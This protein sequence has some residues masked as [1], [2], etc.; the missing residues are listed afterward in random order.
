VDGG[1]L[2]SNCIP[3]FMFTYRIH[4]PGNSGYSF[5]SKSSFIRIAF[6]RGSEWTGA[7]VMEFRDL[8]TSSPV[9]VKS[10]SEEARFSFVQGRYVE[11]FDLQ[12]SLTC[13]QFS[14]ACGLLELY[15]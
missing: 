6:C 13:F 5:T 2:E 3:K 9:E 12:G 10:Y 15:L 4:H 14:V 1:D 11:D 7:Y 8:I